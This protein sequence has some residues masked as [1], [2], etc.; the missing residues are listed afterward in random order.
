MCLCAPSLKCHIHSLT[1]QSDLLNRHSAARIFC[2]QL[3]VCE[4][5]PRLT[6]FV[7]GWGC[8]RASPGPVPPLST[9]VTLPALCFAQQWA[10][11]AFVEFERRKIK[12]TM[13]RVA[14]FSAPLI[15][16]PLLPAALITS[17]PRSFYLSCFLIKTVIY[18]IVL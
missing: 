7:S 1:N 4:L 8:L 11:A 15:P 17:Q 9:Q 12:T 6:G 18:A 2:H 13:D 14:T 3:Q 10:G 16:P 5:H